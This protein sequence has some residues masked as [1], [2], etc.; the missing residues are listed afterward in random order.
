MYRNA[1]W[2]NRDKCIYLQTWNDKGERITE[3]VPFSPYLYV[4]SPRGQYESIFGNM[5]VRKE[6]QT[7]FDRKLFLKNYGSNRVY[8]NF[9]APHQFL[10]DRFWEHCQKPEFSKHPLRILFYDIEVDPLPDGEFPVPE[11][12]KAEINLITFYDSISQRYTIISK[13]EYHGNN[14]GD[15]TDYVKCAD[16]KEL[17]EKLIDF[18]ASNEYPD[19]AS[20]W[21]SNSFDFP[22]IKNRIEKVL[23]HDAF[24]KLSPFGFIK[25]VLSTDNMKHEYTKYDV[26]GVTNIDFIDVYIRFK[27]KLQESYKLDYIA[28]KELGIG[29]IEYDT[30]IHDFM[31]ANWDK[32]VE[33]NKRDVE[34]LVKLEERL[35]YF[36]ILRSLAYGSCI[37]FEKAILTIPVTNGALGV[38][39]RPTG[40][41]LHSF[42]KN[43]SD[44]PL[45]GGFV[46]AKSGFFE[47]VVTY[48]ATSLYPSI[49]ISNNI[50]PETKVAVANPLG[51]FQVLEGSQDDAFT[52]TLANGK[53]YR[54]NRK[55]LNKFVRSQNLVLCPNGAIFT[56]D[57]QG[58][59]PKWIEGI[60]NKRQKIK[61]ELKAKRKELASL[62]NELD[63]LDKT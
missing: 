38:M 50:S 23:G 47:D 30:N 29:K 43:I 55:K 40:K 56:Q 34:L 10:L 59:L 32:F 37:N 39:V 20:A 5:L 6:F 58:I 48:D 14:L 19:I 35:N 63:N 21:N 7:P 62:K 17:L 4:E 12:A 16:E 13:N 46:S 8:E 3:K 42:Q 57:E 1:W 11:E 41:K 15:D 22:Y 44:K 24:L 36:K 2:S 26:A 27:N 45:T 52:L 49:I 61:A 54:V 31:R 53:E 60:F 33:Y 51:M 18:W 28:Q 9:D 25:E